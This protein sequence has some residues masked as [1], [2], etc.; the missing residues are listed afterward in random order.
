MLLMLCKQTKQMENINSIYPAEWLTET[1]GYYVA[2]LE[3]YNVKGE[4]K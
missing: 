1:L 3:H 4:G 2:V